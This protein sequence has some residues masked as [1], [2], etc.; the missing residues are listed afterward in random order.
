[1]LTKNQYSVIITALAT[2]KEFIVT[3]SYIQN[4]SGSVILP[5]EPGMLDWLRENY[6]SSKYYIVEVPGAQT[7]DSAVDTI[8]S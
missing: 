6:P 1:M 7:I 3:R 5:N 2:T 8:E 4:K